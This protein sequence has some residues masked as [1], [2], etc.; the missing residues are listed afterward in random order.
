MSQPTIAQIN[1]R[2][3]SSL[4]TSGDVGLRELGLSPSDAVRALWRRLST[5]GDELSHVRTLL[6]GEVPCEDKPV[7]SFEQSPIAQGWQLVDSGVAALGLANLTEGQGHGHAY[8]N[9][10]ITQELEDRMRERGLM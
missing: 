9:D 8:D 10:L 1:V 6:L 2:L 4:K 3:P 7:R 5:R